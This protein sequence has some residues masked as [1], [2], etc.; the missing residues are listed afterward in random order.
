EPKMYEAEPPTTSEKRNYII[1]G[2]AAAALV[3]GLM[4]VVIAV[5]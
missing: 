4:V 5:S 3:T 1:L 2:I